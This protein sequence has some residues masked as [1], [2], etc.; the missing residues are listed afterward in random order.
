[1]SSFK[2][3]TIYGQSGVCATHSLRWTNE[4]PLWTEE[5]NAQEFRSVWFCFFS[6]SYSSF[7]RAQ[8]FQ[9]TCWAVDWFL[10]DSVNNYFTRIYIGIFIHIQSA[11]T[12][13][14]CIRFTIWIAQNETIATAHFGCN[15]DAYTPQDTRLLCRCVRDRAWC[16]QTKSV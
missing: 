15:D 12:C 16:D 4:V 6:S 14:P 9:T 11:T 3:H 2:R 13:V 1:M 5:K 8:T 10:I 7:M